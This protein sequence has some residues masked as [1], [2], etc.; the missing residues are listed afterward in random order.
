MG[1][2]S[3]LFGSSSD[4]IT[5]TLARTYVPMFIKQM[6]MSTSEARKTFRDILKDAER[7]SAEEGTSELPTNFGDILLKEEG[8]DEKVTSMLEK[9]RRE[10]VRNDD[11]R[12]W[13]NMHDIERR[14]MVAFDDVM[15]ITAYK[16]LTEDEGLNADD[17]KRRIRSSFPIFG[18]SDDTRYTSGENRPLPF[19]LKDRI[20][21]YVEKR[22]ETDPKD[23]EKEIQASSSLNAFIRDKIKVGEI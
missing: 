8:V 1:F 10:G 12:W 5:E 20:N 21:I 9:K 18:D 4:E 17:A 7:K 23:L 14:M 19:E 6:G 13:W 15:K 3:K 11:I 2:F 16:V 22:K